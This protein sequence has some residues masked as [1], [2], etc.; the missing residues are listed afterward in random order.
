MERTFPEGIRLCKA[1]AREI[2]GLHAQTHEW[3]NTAVPPGENPLAKISGDLFD[4]EAEVEPGDAAEFGFV[5]RGAKVSYA[6]AG[7]KLSA[8]G[9][10]AELAPA[11]G[12]VKLRLLVDRA[13]LEIFGNDGS[14][15]MSSCFLPRPDDRKLAFYAT[16]GAAKII[17][18]QVRELKPAWPKI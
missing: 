12:P 17:S 11:P 7:R 13:S 2:A 4:I 8:L 1:P 6:V 5:I 14:V 15:T 18:L 9:K 16:G 3:K 10:S